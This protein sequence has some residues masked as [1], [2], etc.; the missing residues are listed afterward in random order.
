MALSRRDLV[1]RCLVGTALV[2]L[3]SLVIA[4]LVYTAQNNKLD[5]QTLK[6]H[7][8]TVRRL[9][10]RRIIGEDTDAPSSSPAPTTM[11]SSP[12]PSPSPSAQ[13][14]TNPPAPPTEPPSPPKSTV[15][16]ADEATIDTTNAS[17][18]ALPATQESS[19]AAPTSLVTDAPTTTVQPSPAPT[20]PRVFPF[21]DFQCICGPPGVNHHPQLREWGC[22]LLFINTLADVR[23]EGIDY[24]L[25]LTAPDGKG[26]SGQGT[27]QDA[28]MAIEKR[29]QKCR[30]LNWRPGK[31]FDISFKLCDPETLP[32]APKA[33][34]DVCYIRSAAE[35]ERCA[36]TLP[37]AQIAGRPGAP[38]LWLQQRW[39][40]FTPYHN[41]FDHGVYQTWLGLGMIRQFIAAN[42]LP[43]LAEVVNRTT[44]A[45]TTRP[46][47][48]GEYADY[49]VRGMKLPVL[50]EAEAL[51]P[52]LD[53]YYLD[54]GEESMDGVGPGRGYEALASGLSAL[55]MNI[56]M[57]LMYGDAPRN[58]KSR[59]PIHQAWEAVLRPQRF[60]WYEK[61]MMY[62]PYVALN[63]MT[64]TPQDGYARDINTK[65]RQIL[66]Y[67][68]LFASAVQTS[69]LRRYGET[70]TGGQVPGHVF[71]EKRKIADFDRDSRARG[72][73]PHLQAQLIKGLGR[74]VPWLKRAAAE[75]KSLSADQQLT[76]P[77]AWSLGETTTS[78]GL[79]ITERQLS[80]EIPYKH[81]WYWIRSA[82]V[83]LAGEGAFISFMQLS[84]PNT[85]WICIFNHTKPPNE[86]KMSIFHAQLAPA[87]DYIRL[88]FYVIDNGV[89][90]PV[91]DLWPLVAK[92]PFEPGVFFVGA[93]ANGNRKK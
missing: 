33:M 89:A 59:E 23:T 18:T 68:R 11:M 14:S 53:P 92:E 54:W 84:A 80:K 91:S 12:V 42:G 16:A 25:H 5:H 87:Y 73:Q 52:Y 51:A 6:G 62:A 85:T 15:A 49:V 28:L 37:E 7:I 81:Q 40:G 86:A 3:M 50:P 71:I 20:A 22:N 88:I 8:N 9:V 72:I 30:D 2:V 38:L 35:A 82:R 26:P 21:S 48:N 27:P 24:Y 56:V 55:N 44:L 10:G 36:P 41:M 45:N 61:G 1:C 70:P 74:E 32:G 75:R 17:Q 4:A 19:T 47:N 76:F 77:K 69:L 79:L 57:D 66:W 34:K 90:D 78:D 13:P 63:M 65:S 93:D 64:C 83:I 29:F 43:P 60:D 67:I 31:R 46:F 39:G 58:P